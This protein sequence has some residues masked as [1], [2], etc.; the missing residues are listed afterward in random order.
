MGSLFRYTLLCILRSPG[1]LVWTLAFPLILSGVFSFMFVGI[2]ESSAERTVSV[3]VVDDAAYEADGSFQTFV[4]EASRGEDRAVDAVHVESVADAEALLDDGTVDVAV[5]LDDGGEH[6]ILV[7]P[8][9]GGA[10]QIDWGVARALLD[11]YAQAEGV[12]EVLASAALSGEAGVDPAR[13]VEAFSGERVST[14][15]LDVLRV[16][17]DGYSR[18]YYALLGMATLMGANIS[19]HMVAMTRANCSQLG[20]RRQTSALSPTRQLA[21]T[22]GASWVATFAC[23]FVA[24]LFMRFVIGVEFGGRDALAVAAL[25]VCA[26]VATGFGAFLGAVPRLSEGA[27]SG[28]CTAASCLLSVGAGLYGEP[29]MQ[30]ADWL[31]RNAPAAQLANPAAQVVEVFY[32]LA[33]YDSLLPFAQTAAVLL[34]MAAA[35]FAGSAFLMRRQRY[36]RL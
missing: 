21:S 11:G 34:A 7:S 19:L 32:D 8:E 4:E 2:E 36:A 29:A 18:Y 3:A 10:S 30:L 15:Q 6:Y 26:L 1:V 9:A 23:L 20:A 35:L 22:I 5:A 14:E 13:A 24:F 25:A 31:S 12:Q 33:Y 17:A 28:I 16:D 27:R